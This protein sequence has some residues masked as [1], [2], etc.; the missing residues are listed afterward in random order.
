MNTD[1]VERVREKPQPKTIKKRGGIWSFLFGA[2]AALGISQSGN[3]ADYSKESI[4]SASQVLSQKQDQNYIHDFIKNLEDEQ[5]FV[6]NKRELEDLKGLANNATK[7]DISNV[8]VKYSSIIHKMQQYKRGKDI[9]EKNKIDALIRKMEGEEG[10]F[11]SYIS[12][13]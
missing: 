13:K 2:G 3:I 7:D 10:R 12:S 9:E 1:Y 4:S 11:L 6:D 8:Q 5:F